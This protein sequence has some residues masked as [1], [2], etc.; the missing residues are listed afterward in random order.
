MEVDG[1]GWLSRS[2]RRKGCRA[3]VPHKAKRL[4]RWESSMI[5]VVMS[6]RTLRAI[7][8]KGCK[9][10]E[11]ET[12]FAACNQLYDCSSQGGVEVATKKPEPSLGLVA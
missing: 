4:D 9:R 11:R 8:M 6:G 2:R 1:G 12:W 3:V 5:W 10:N 7:Q